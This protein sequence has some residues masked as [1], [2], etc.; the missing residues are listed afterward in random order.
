FFC[1]LHVVTSC[2]QSEVNCP[3]LDIPCTEYQK[4][5][6]IST[7]S[8]SSFSLPLQKS[9][10]LGHKNKD[11]TVGLPG[12]NIKLYG[13][14]RKRLLTKKMKTILFAIVVAVV[15]GVLIYYRVLV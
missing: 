13:T 5:C 10:S 2:L 1:V 9:V 11:F 6:P 12:T 8:V 3:L 7:P 4:Q 14:A 15:V